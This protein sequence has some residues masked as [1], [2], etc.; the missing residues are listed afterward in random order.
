MNRGSHLFLVL[1]ALATLAATGTTPIQAADLGGDCCADLEERVGELEAT[2]ARKGNRKVSLTI[3]GYV[4]QEVTWWDDGGES[5]VYLHGLG[6]TQATHVK[7]TGEAKIAPGWTA[8]YTLRIQNLDDNPFGRNAAT[9]QAMNQFSPDFSQ[10]LNVQM[11]YWF[12]Q[13]KEL[14]KVS[15]GRQADAAKSAAMFTDQSGTQIIDN[16]TFLAGFPQFVIRS[17]GNLAPPSLTWGQLGFCYSQG[18]PL[19]GD[20]DGL[21]MNS[22]RYDTPV[23]LGCSASASWGE[24]DDWEI[25]ARYTGVWS[26][27]KVLLGVGYSENTDAGVSVALPAGS[28]KDTNFF[29]TGGYIQHLAT[30]L[31]IHGAFGREDNSNTVLAGGITPP[32]SHQW[33][34][35]GGIRQNWTSLGATIVYADYAQYNDQLGPG[36][37]ALGATSST[38]RRFGGGI[39]QEIDA[40]AMTVYLKYQRYDADVAGLSPSV[41]NLD[42]AEFISAGGLIN[43]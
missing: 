30:G 19:G 32:N 31:F 23:F 36:A 27:F 21:V 8:G 13:S 34:F 18:V 5:N 17:G 22:V 4:A 37:L 42:S 40:V 35:K 43:F 9:G 39:A 24:D 6:P 28:K 20:C 29:Q 14:G 2:T 25:A 3:S 11:S 7:F 12:L 38:L 33:Y 16:Y 41:G 26:G 15:V 1:S 10:G